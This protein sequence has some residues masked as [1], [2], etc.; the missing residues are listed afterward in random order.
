MPENV[1]KGSIEAAT[2]VDFESLL[3]QNTYSYCFHLFHVYTKAA[4]EVESTGNHEAG[5][6]F[7]YLAILCSFRPNYE[8]RE[9]PYHPARIIGEKRSILPEDL[10][11]SDVDVVK[12]LFSRATE[13]ALKARFGDILWI[14]RKDIDAARVAA[15]NY[16][17]SGKRLINN[18]HGWSQASYEFTRA[19][20]LATFLGRKNE[21]FP[22]IVTDIEAAI[23]AIPPEEKSFRAC[24]LMNVLLD[25][26]A[27]NPSVMLGVAAK[28]A[29]AT[30][31]DYHKSREYWDAEEKW[32]KRAGK[33]EE[34]RAAA[35]KSARTLVEEARS[36]V[37]GLEP[38]YIVGS[39]FLA[40]GIE[41]LRRNG[42]DAKEIESL[43][44]TLLEW[45]A[46]SKH[47][48]K[49]VDYQV[50][51][52]EIVK[53]ARNHVDC[54]GFEAAVVKLVCGYPLIN[55][56]ELRTEVIETANSFPISHMFGASYVDEDGR[57]LDTGI[58]L[59]DTSAPGYEEEVWR[60]MVVHATRYIWGLR[61]QAYIELARDVIW[62]KHHPRA[63][64]IRWLWQGHPFV[65]PG[66]EEI[67]GRGL[68]AG[69]HAD[70]LIVAHLLVPQIENSIRHVLKINGVDVTN[71]M[72]DMTQP[73]K[74]SAQVIG[75]EKA[76]EI[77]GEDMMFELKGLLL[78]KRG[79]QLRHQIAHGMADNRDCYSSA[80]INIWWLFLRLCVIGASN[81]NSTATTPKEV[82]ESPE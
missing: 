75:H 67:I 36:R 16:N 72:S 39:R 11:D 1:Y 55:P 61:A 56:S 81:A 54:T 64:D 25:Q 8:D 44:L 23:L 31:E 12:I 40:Q 73:L 29:E 80:T 26:Q 78:E 58:G 71:L 50:D 59:H 53:N 20:Q 4:S 52:S 76:K 77:F 42:G 10:T 9:H 46:Q 21:P 41:S 18:E 82:T 3:S 6:L 48:M 63:K 66:H 14:Q 13:P 74:V 68:L 65:P 15:K 28:H 70:W 34:A 37:I 22:S 32:Q 60:Q 35:L 27:G 17:T 30:R 45:Q 57:I 49:L 69:F 19:L 5:L 2:V 33:N 7:D 43:K 38:S 51:I 24:Q 62:H 47:E 79:F